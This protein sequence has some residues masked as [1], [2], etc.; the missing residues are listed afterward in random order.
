MVW[1]CM[2]ASGVR[3]LVFIDDKMDKYCYKNILQNNLQKSADNLGIGGDYYF[4]QDNDP[5]HI[6]K[7]VRLWILYN[8][9]H[10]LKTPP[11]SPDLNPIENLW[12]TLE[13]RIR[14]HHISSKIQLKQ[15]LLEEWQHRPIGHADIS[16]FYARP[17][18]R[19]YSQKGLGNTILECFSI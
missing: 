6:T 8:T 1:G 9:P 14:R 13:R 18:D 16:S 10:T 4:Q 2:A 5:K 19:S 12:D 15:V 17:L 3:E 11:Q 7:I